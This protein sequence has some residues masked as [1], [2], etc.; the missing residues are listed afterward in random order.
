MQ[1]NLR[2]SRLPLAGVIAATALVLTACGGPTSGGKSDD[3]KGAPKDWGKAAGEVEFWDTNANPTGALGGVWEK[4]IA[5]FE[6][7]FPDI[8]V[9][10]VG[11]PNSSYLQKV[12]NALATHAT[13]DVM[14]IGND[15]ANFI[16]QSALTP[17][18]QA[19]KDAG[20]TDQI[21][22]KHVD[23][24]RA[25]AP[26]KLLYSGPL[27][28]L[29]DVIWYR[30]DWLTAKGIKAPTSYD[31]FFSV[32]KQ[33]TDKSSNKFG[34]AFRG[35]AGSMPPLLA[36]TY[37]MSGVGEF[38]TKDDKSTLNDP[39]NVEALKRYISLYTSVSAKGD[40]TNDFV[41]IVAEFDGGSAWATH[42]NLGSYQDHIKAIG[43]TAVAGVQPF[44]NSDGVITAT[45]PAISGLTIFQA[46]KQKAAAWEFVKYMMTDGNSSWAQAA[47]QVPA[48]LTAA[49]AKWV[50]DS[51]PLR[52]IVETSK[53]PKTQ[54]VQL[55][56]FLPD[57]GSITKTQMEPDLQAILAGSMS[58]EDFTSKYADKFDVALKEYKDHAKK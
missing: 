4:Q 56:V 1:R 17:L 30:T 43:T 5:A 58:V 3:A 27:T 32:A 35:G 14:L 31:E 48:N 54:Y 34:Y 47:G 26:D 41:K 37:G 24:V 18:D 10:Y 36:M 38:F 33:L 42:H 51:Q 13:P 50:Q 15:I 22:P 25:N 46:S 29:S 40:L 28:A 9:K 45:R 21:D 12:N 19:F 49:Q 57:W 20:L 53:N 6:K 7:K 23:G 2:R 8:H 44:P 55:P 52:A 11:L 39:K 16:A